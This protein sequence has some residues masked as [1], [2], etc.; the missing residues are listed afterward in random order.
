MVTV[1]NGDTFGFSRDKYW[2]LTQTSIAPGYPR[3]I[4]EG[5]NGLP[6]DLDAAFTCTNGRT[7]FFKE[8][9][10][11]RFSEVGVLDDGYPNDTDR[12]FAGAPKP[13]FHPV[14]S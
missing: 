2:K 10:Y 12:G 7:Y 3:P 13:G 14:I 5:W 1:K 6:N 4:E 9:R 8:S 11:W